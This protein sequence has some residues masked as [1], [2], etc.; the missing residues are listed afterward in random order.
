M[1]AGVTASEEPGRRPHEAPPAL[2]RAAIGLVAA[3]AVLRIAI[4]LLSS[5]VA[6]FS[7]MA[8]YLEASRALASGAG[9]PATVDRP[10]LYPV[11]LAGLARAGLGSLLA[12]YLVQSALSLAAVAATAWYAWRI[13]GPRAGW[14]A[15]ALLAPQ[16]TIAQYT[17]LALSESLFLPLL[18]VWLALA[19]PGSPDSGGSLGAGR[20]RGVSDA[21]MAAARIAGAGVAA[22]IT[23][24]LRPAALPLAAGTCLALGVLGT[25]RLRSSAIFAAAAAVALA[26]SVFG[27][28]RLAGVP[29]AL[30]PT[31][32]VN[33]YLGN[34]P[35]GRLDGGGLE[36]LPPSLESIA[37]PAERNAEA[38][39]QALRE[40]ARRPL[41]TALNGAVRLLRL[42]SVNPGRVEHDALVADGFPSWVVLLWLA[43]EWG[44]LAV[45]SAVAWRGGAVSHGSRLF[46]SLVAVPYVFVLALTYVQ[47][48]YRLPL[49]PLLAPFAARG[50]AQLAAAPRAQDGLRRFLPAGLAAG[51]VVVIA[52]AIDLLL[53]GR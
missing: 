45:L 16:L 21:R 11:L 2:W 35:G 40:M 19:W 17:G 4:A 10:L 31:V 52:S 15:A 51:A 32:G 13:G 25:R 46:T 30:V 41:R 48:R 22:G 14:I 50:A 9:L 6:P 49:V 27:A 18:A 20:G 7:D 28:A 8:W 37:D 38:G 44:G 12:I 34:G 36:R 47:T 5:R 42:M 53:K 39:R 24:A 26:A 29:A 33:L 1:T 23:A 43:L 3:G